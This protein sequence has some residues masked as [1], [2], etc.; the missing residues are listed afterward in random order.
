M[1]NQTKDKK[2]R[3]KKSSI[4][5]QPYPSLIDKKRY[6]WIIVISIS[7]YV[8]LFLILFQP[9]ALNRTTMPNKIL[10]LAGY[11][12]VT[13][14]VLVVLLIFAPKILKTFFS[15]E[16]WTVGK[17]ILW[18]IMILFGIGIG[19]FLY[20]VFYIDQFMKTNLLN[21]NE[22]DFNKIKLHFSIKFGYF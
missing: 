9:F 7:L 10:F 8:S 21:Y 11:G 13:F 2:K 4:L 22:E 14:I 15:F 20:S 12:G 5:N 19:N 16:R 18:L 6:N 17:H 3:Q 1:K